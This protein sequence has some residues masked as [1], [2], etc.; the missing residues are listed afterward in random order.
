MLKSVR[1]SLSSLF[2]SLIVLL[3]TMVVIGLLVSASLMDFIRDDEEQLA[4]RL[5]V[6]MSW[7]T[8]ARAVVSMFEITLANWSPA[9][10]LLTNN[11]NEAWAV[12]FLLYK[13]SIGFAVLQVIM[14]VFIQQTFRVAS[15]DEELMIKERHSF[16]MA[17]MATMKRLFAAVDLSG[18]GFIER[19]ELDAVLGDVRIKSWFSALDVDMSELGDVFD[20]MD[21]NGDGF[22]SIDEFFEVL[23]IVKGTAR[24]TDMYTLVKHLTKLDKTVGEMNAKLCGGGAPLPLTH[25]H[26]S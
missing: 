25:P 6:Y 1:A 5:L 3:V 4:T 18:D 17:Q 22:I 21:L 16:A 24:R 10:W 14:S 7:G 15:R 20:F 19:D 8:L 12:F 26:P 11:V 23:K 13:C 2:W 9:C